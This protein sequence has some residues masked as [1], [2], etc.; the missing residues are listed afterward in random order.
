MKFQILKRTLAVTLVSAAVASAASGQTLTNGVWSTEG[1]SSVPS[2]V[3]PAGQATLKV[4]IQ[5][6]AGTY[7]GNQGSGSLANLTIALY[8]Q[9]GSPPVA[10]VSYSYVVSFVGGGGT[11]LVI[12]APAANRY[13]F[14]LGLPVSA[15]PGI[16]IDV[17]SWQIRATYNPVVDAS[18]GS[19]GAISPQGTIAE[20]YNGSQVFTATP[21]SGYGVNQWL[22]DGS[23]VRVGGNSYTLSSIQSYHTVHV[24]FAALGPIGPTGPTGPKGATG[25]TGPT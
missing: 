3:V 10:G 20:P 19:G 16:F 1:T 17:T 2:I 25:A 7:F 4:D 5:N 18:A 11:T 21:N 24:T 15:A 14:V 6:V 13:Y 12:N 9:V 23:G 22:V 8:S